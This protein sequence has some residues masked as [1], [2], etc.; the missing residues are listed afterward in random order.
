MASQEQLYVFFLWATVCSGQLQH[1]LYCTST[2]GMAANSTCC[3]KTEFNTESAYLAE[4][5][6]FHVKLLHADKLYMWHHRAETH[7][8]AHPSGQP[9]TVLGCF[10]ARGSRYDWLRA[11][12]FLL[13]SSLPVGP[14]RGLQEHEVPLQPC[15]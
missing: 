3:L 7:P 4:M 1:N 14:L 12:V 15:L 6:E 11:S 5:H 8:D 10:F 9:C 2:G 13:L